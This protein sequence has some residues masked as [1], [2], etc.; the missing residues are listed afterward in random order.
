MNT[1]LTS[2]YMCGAEAKEVFLTLLVAEV[3]QEGVQR[4]AIKNCSVERNETLLDIGPYN[5]IL[6]SV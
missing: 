4:I 2:F 1:Y 3:T 6:A 5:I